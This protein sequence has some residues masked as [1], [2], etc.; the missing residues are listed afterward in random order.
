LFKGSKVVQQ[1]PAPT[2]LVHRDAVV[3]LTVTMPPPG[4]GLLLGIVSKEPGYGKLN[5]E[6]RQILDQFL[7]QTK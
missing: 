5:P 4:V 2:T 1:D 7:G 3:T 6:Y